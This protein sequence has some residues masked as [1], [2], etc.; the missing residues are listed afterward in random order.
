MGKKKTFREKLADNKDLPK[1]EPIPERMKAKW[2]EGTIVIP[3]PREV[4]EAMRAVPEG[5]L[6]EINDIRKQ[7]ARR[8]GADI[9]CPMTTGIFATIAARAAEEAA[10]QGETGITPY[11]RTLK[12]GGELNP[13]YPGGVERQAEKL[14]AEGHRVIQKGKR[15]WVQGFESSRVP[16]VL[17]SSWSWSAPRDG[18][19][20]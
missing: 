11:W 16:L 10:A 2:G 9:G 8:H 20:D 7:L 3:A 12:A 13:K 17:A 1:V 19:V 14:R 5:G 4:D 18:G 15:W 6:I